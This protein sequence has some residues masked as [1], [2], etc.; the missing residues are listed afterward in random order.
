MP[1]A[2]PTNLTVNGR[3]AFSLNF[4]WAPVPRDY[5]NGLPS[6]Y[7]VNTLRR[8]TIVYTSTVDFFT[9]NIDLQNL[10]PS[11]RYILE[12]CAFNRVGLGPCDRIQAVTKDSGKIC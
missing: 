8:T 3:T 1:D 5:M 12:V 9:T 7:I 4:E 11:T 6:G 2:P 10:T